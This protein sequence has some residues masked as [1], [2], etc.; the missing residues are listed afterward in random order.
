MKILD[1]LGYLIKGPLLSS[2]I[3]NSVSDHEVSSSNNF[4]YSLH[5]HF[6]HNVEWSIDIE[7][8]VAT[9]STALGLTLS[10]KILNCPSL[11]WTIVSVP[12]YNLL[13]F[14]IF[15]TP[16]IKDFL[17]MDIL[18]VFTHVSEELPP[19]GVGVPYL[20]VSCSS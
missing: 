11:V 5:W 7:T 4:N 3:V 19:A 18:E 12:N 8:K 9:Q 14:S 13:T 1:S 6:R 10:I 2:S 16:N 17:V 20:H 15:S